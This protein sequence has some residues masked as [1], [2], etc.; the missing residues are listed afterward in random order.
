MSALPEETCVFFYRSNVL[1]AVGIANGIVWEYDEMKQRP[2]G[3]R[4]YIGWRKPEGRLRETKH[5]EWKVGSSA[6][7]AVGSLCAEIN[8]RPQSQI[9][10]VIIL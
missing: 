6:D 7:E 2:R 3:H 9:I 8:S 10:N 4:T 5:R 1:R